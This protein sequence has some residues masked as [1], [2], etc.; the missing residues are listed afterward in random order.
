[1]LRAPQ[2][3]DERLFLLGIGAEVEPGGH[4]VCGGRGQAD[5]LTGTPKREGD[6]GGEAGRGSQEKGMESIP[7]LWSGDHLFF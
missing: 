1:M 5:R 2:Q 4:W 7:E 3:K 6:W